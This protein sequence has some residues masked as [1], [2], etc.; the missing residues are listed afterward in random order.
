[1]VYVHFIGSGSL[2][3]SDF[4]LREVSTVDGRLGSGGVGCVS[5]LVGTVSSCNRDSGL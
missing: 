4:G 3:L 1:L 2:S 5:L